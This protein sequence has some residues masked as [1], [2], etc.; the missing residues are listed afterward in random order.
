[1]RN[2]IH[3]GIFCMVLLCAFTATSL[4]AQV[5][6]KPEPADNPNL[7][8][9]SV[10]TAAC[11]SA[12]FNEY[13]VNFTWNPPLVASDN[14]FVL[15]LSDANGDFDSPRELARVAD[16]NTNFDFNFE[17]SIPTDVQGDNY[18][19]RVISTNPSKT[20]LE[21]DTF[22]M[23][24]IGYNDPILISKDGS[25]TIPPGGRIALCAGES[26]N[27]ATHNVPDAENYSFNWYRSGTPLSEQSNSLD[28]VDSGMYYVEIDYGV[29]C[30][31]SANTLSNTIEVVAVPPLNVTISAAGNTS[32]CTGDSVMLNAN[33]NEPTYEYTWFQ[34]NIAITAP[35]LGASSFL[36]DASISDFEGEYHVAVKGDEPC[37]EISNAINITNAGVFDVDLVNETE[38]IILPGQTKTLEVTTT[39]GSPV[40]QWYK[41]GT[42]ISDATNATITINDVGSYYV[43]VSQSG[44]SC[45]ASPID[46]D[47]TTVALPVAFEF[48]I[49]PG[50]SYVACSSAS[51]KVGLELINA[52]TDNGTRINVTTDLIDEFSLQWI[53]DGVAV[54][55]AT[56]SSITLNDS[57][58][59]GD[60]VLE[61][62]LE[63]F[64]VSSNTL[65]I[66]LLSGDDIVITS[67]AVAVCIG[68]TSGV[69]ITTDY[70]LTGLTFEWVKDGVSFSTNTSIEATETGDYHL[71]V[72][73]DG[74]SL[75]SNTITIVPFDDSALTLDTDSSIL[76]VEGSTKIVTASG[77]DNYSWY[78]EANQLVVEDASITIT[79]PGEYLLIAT[80]SG[81]QVSRTL[82]VSLKENFAIPNVITV[83]G[84][85]INDL[86]I[87]PNSYSNQNDV[88]V[89]IYN[90]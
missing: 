64:N 5:L 80:V 78:N 61:G 46:S 68:A 48:E 86:W 24:Y 3:H 27:L 36:V 30:S 9:N 8:G 23:Y 88:T 34:N 10:W 50:V 33:I 7:P 74:C 21:S 18:K 70:D 26:L 22:S 20:S 19:F 1:M 73:K 32:L 17:F 29:N 47:T 52:V 54:P 45:A 35:T 59:N 15:E 67:D 37:A 85:G 89:I 82:S 72:E 51:T 12:D 44:G 41:D 63:S 13:F 4:Q 66:N 57:A 6:N 87:L 16:K 53:L 60:Y 2:F 40:Y 84:D 77:A 58:N 83:N 76:L 62:S 38:L 81:C 79:E 56:S 11:A 31:G 75:Q 49:A 90:E 28:V 43:Q 14:E 65:A 39:A 25:G 69:E 55:S 71:S 42:P